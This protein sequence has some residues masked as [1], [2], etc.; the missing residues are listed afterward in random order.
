[1]IA[2]SSSATE[3]AVLVCSSDG[4][5]WASIELDENGR[6]ELPLDA[7]DR[8]TFAIGSAFDFAANDGLF[9]VFF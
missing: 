5:Q 8:D 7:H 2:V 9:I 1:M 4:T 3:A 6:C